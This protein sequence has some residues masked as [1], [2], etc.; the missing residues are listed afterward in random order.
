VKSLWGTKEK[1][2][3][4]HVRDPHY[5]GILSVNIV[6]FHIASG[7]LSRVNNYKFIITLTTSKLIF[8]SDLL[9]TNKNFMSWNE[10][11]FV[12][13]KLSFVW[14]D[15]ALRKTLSRK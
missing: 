10:C 9:D 12:Q 1:L 14:I 11:M 7:V 5:L 15:T 8:S 2:P 13:R 4:E 3:R 6:I